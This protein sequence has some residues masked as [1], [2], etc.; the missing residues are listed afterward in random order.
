MNGSIVKRDRCRGS[1]RGR[2]WLWGLSSEVVEKCPVMEVIT[3]IGS[4]TDETTSLLQLRWQ[5]MARATRWKIFQTNLELDL[6]WV[7]QYRNEKDM[8]LNNDSKV[9]LQSTKIPHRQPDPNRTINPS[10]PA[11]PQTEQKYSQTPTPTASPTS[12]K[13]QTTQS[14]QGLLKLP[15]LSPPP[16]HHRHHQPTNNCHCHPDLK[17]QQHGPRRFEDLLCMDI[18]Q[19]HEIKHSTKRRFGKGR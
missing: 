19:L 3:I 16:P 2:R 11:N 6:G 12:S 14:L 5:S 10:G 9:S 7:E 4:G 17:T 13:S 1:R 18:Q 15:P 8:L